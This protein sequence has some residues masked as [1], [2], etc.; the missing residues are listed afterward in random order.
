MEVATRTLPIPVSYLRAGSFTENWLRTVV[1]VTRFGVEKF[2]LRSSRRYR[3]LDRL[4]RLL[5]RYENLLATYR[6]FLYLACL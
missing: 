4:R 5:V 6:A 3:G 1:G 2:C